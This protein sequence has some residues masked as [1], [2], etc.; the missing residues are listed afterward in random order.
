MDAERPVRIL[1]ADDHTILRESVSEVLEMV[2][3]FEVVAQARDGAEALNLAEETKPDVLLLDIEM[4]VMGAREAMSRLSRV[5]PS[6]K[7]II[8]TMF[9]NPDLVRE[10]FAR[11]ASAYLAKTV[12]QQELVST[13]QSV[14]RGED[15]VILSISREALEKLDGFATNILSARQLEILLL[16]ARG[17]SNSQIASSLYLTEGTVKRHLHNIYAKIGVVSRGEA[18]RKALEEGWIT[19]RDITGVDGR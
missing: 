17:K 1:I 19:A 4:P 9:D 16:V 11:G 5:S 7:V 2:E 14:A 13:V 8:L 10:L 3:N 18:V 15:K 12:S 6:S